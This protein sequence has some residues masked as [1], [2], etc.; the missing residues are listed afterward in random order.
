MD[1]A[2]HVTEMLDERIPHLEATSQ[3]TTNVI[4]SD[5]AAQFC[6]SAISLD[7]LLYSIQQKHALRLQPACPTVHMIL[8]RIYVL[9]PTTPSGHLDTSR[10]PNY[11]LDTGHRLPFRPSKPTCETLSETLSAKNVALMLNVK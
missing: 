3:D 9:G 4:H 8:E 2:C 6:L 11:C 5:S 7:V 10:K 1:V